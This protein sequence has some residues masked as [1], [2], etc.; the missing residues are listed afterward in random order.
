MSTTGRHTGGGVHTGGGGHGLG[1]D[2]VVNACGAVSV[3]VI[4]AALKVSG[5]PE[6]GAERAV[7]CS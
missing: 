6:W 7:I 1:G 5:D 2:L 3:E 4:V